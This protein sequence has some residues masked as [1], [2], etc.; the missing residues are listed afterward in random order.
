MTTDPTFDYDTL[1]AEARTA[2]GLSDFGDPAFEAPFR[3]MLA[4][5]DAMP[6]TARGRKSTRRRLSG[7]LVNRLRVVDA[8]AKH[9][10]IRTRTITRPLFLTGLPRTGTSALFNLLA[11]DASARPLLFWEGTHPDPLPAPLAPGEEDPRLVAL[12]DALERGRKANPGFA[13]IHD[14]R[15]DGP[16]ECVQLLAHSLAGVQL[17]VEPLFSPYRESFHAQDQG[18]PYALYADL[19]RLLDH[20]RP[21]ARWLLKTP[22]HLFALDE[23]VTRFPDGTI[24]ITHR[25]LLECVPSYCS[26]VQA[27]LGEHENVDPRDVGARVVDYLARSVERAMALRETLDADRFVDVSY[28]DFVADP[29]ATGLRI[30][31]AAGL[32]AGPAVEASFRAHVAAHPQNKHGKHTYDLGGF[33]LTVEEIRARF[34]AYARRYGVPIGGELV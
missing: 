8:L 1:L 30:H 16:E 6:L 15:A 33:G 20:Q 9:P 17:G 27:M 34:G 14:V 22:A 32:D 5:Y 10:E 29:V 31:R 11:A 18:P 12:R 21:G 3:V 4:S 26:M 23:L 13:A 19:L 24:V 2:T 28:A 25:D 7:L